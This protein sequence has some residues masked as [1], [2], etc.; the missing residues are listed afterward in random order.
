MV[1]VVDKCIALLSRPQLVL[2]SALLEQRAQQIQLFTAGGKCH[3]AGQLLILNGAVRGG[4]GAMKGA[5]V[6]AISHFFS[7][8]NVSR[9]LTPESASAPALK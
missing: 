1:A 4:C 6:L 2:D 5:C 9:L 3:M 8:R 7:H